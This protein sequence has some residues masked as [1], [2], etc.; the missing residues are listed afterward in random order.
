MTSSKRSSLIATHPPGPTPSAGP[1]ASSACQHATRRPAPSADERRVDA[2]A[3]LVGERAARREGAADRQVGRIGRAAGNDGQR[4][5]AVGAHV[6]H[7]GEQGPRVRVTRARRRSAAGRSSTIRPAYMTRTRSQTWRTT[8]MSW[9]IS[10]IATSSAARMRLQQAQ[11]LPL[12]GH[13][14]GGGRLV[15]QDERGRAHQ[16][17]A[18]HRPLPHAAGELV[19]VLPRAG[20]R[21]AGSR[22]A[23]SRSTARAQAGRA[24]EALVLRGPPRPAGRRCA[25]SG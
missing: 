4:L 18:D 22:T 9:L 20:V 19:R 15:G 3:V 16:P 13:V 25:W 10:R 21:R 1:S 14:Q 17:H 7:G 12:H 8:V 23:R 2:L 5:V 24:V 6:R 11:H